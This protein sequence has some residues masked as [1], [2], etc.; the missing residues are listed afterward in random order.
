MGIDFVKTG[1]SVGVGG[2]DEVMEYW[3]EKTGRTES[4]RNAKDITRLVAAGLG[5]AMQIFW[6][7]QA[8]LGES[9]ALSATPLLVKSI[10]KPIRAAMT[11]SQAGSRTFV[12]RRRAPAPPLPGIHASGSETVF[13]P[14]GEE[15]IMSVT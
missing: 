3:D 9:L 6:P 1:I 2:L 11:S 8:R 7:R 14:R 13:T 12:P 4:F 15:V 10:A 5:Y